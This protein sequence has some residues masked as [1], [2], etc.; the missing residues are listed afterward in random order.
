VARQLV[1]EMTALVETGGA[2]AQGLVAQLAPEHFAGL[3]LLFKLLQRL[4]QL[5]VALLVGGD[6][7]PD[8]KQKTRRA[9]PSR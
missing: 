1:V 9:L 2:V 4:C 3:L 6:V 8:A 5:R 7:G